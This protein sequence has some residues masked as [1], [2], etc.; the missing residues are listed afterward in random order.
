MDRQGAGHVQYVPNVIHTRSA[1]V[2]CAEETAVTSII[3]F[4][5]AIL[6]DS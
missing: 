5:S 6:P 1:P 3:I 2:G 4:S